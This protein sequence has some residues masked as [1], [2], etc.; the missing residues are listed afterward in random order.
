MNNRKFH[1]VNLALAVALIALLAVFAADGVSADGAD[2]ES[3]RSRT[4]VKATAEPDT[5]KADLR[6]ALVEIADLR[7][8]NATFMNSVDELRKALDAKDGAIDAALKRIAEQE[9]TIAALR[10][11]LDEL[12]HL[13]AQQAAPFVWEANTPSVKM[14]TSYRTTSD[15]EQEVERLLNVSWFPVRGALRYDVEAY[16]LVY[17]RCAE[18]V[19]NVSVPQAQITFVDNCA[20]YDTFMVTVTAYNA[21]LETTVSPTRKAR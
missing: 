3:H 14:V 20:Q 1:I 11:E 16:S 19:R 21:D 18:T 5:S 13:E 4:G 7:E 9:A 12:R 6:A 17:P 2:D 8:R 15:G 10:F